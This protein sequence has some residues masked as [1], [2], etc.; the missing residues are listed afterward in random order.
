MN[1]TTGDYKKSHKKTL[2][3]LNLR[4]FTESDR[5]GSKFGRAGKI[6]LLLDLRAVKHQGT[7][8]G[9]TQ[10]SSKITTKGGQDNIIYSCTPAITLL[11]SDIRHIYPKSPY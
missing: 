5:R 1:V 11:L 10:K 4:G 8:R 6:A 3:T 7:T 9:T 2:Q